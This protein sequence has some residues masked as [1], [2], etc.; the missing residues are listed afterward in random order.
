MAASSL[1]Y[2]SRYWAISPIV[3]NLH[4][5]RSRG[6][7]ADGLIA[8]TRANPLIKVPVSLCHVLDWSPLIFQSCL[9]GQCTT[10][11]SFCRNGQNVPT[12][13]KYSYSLPFLKIG[14]LTPNLY[15]LKFCHHIQRRKRY[16]STEGSRISSLSLV[17]SLIEEPISLQ[18]LNRLLTANRVPR[19]HNRWLEL[20]NVNQAICMDEGTSS[21]PTNINLP[22]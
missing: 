16:S 14:H 4:I 21:L 13:L 2:W 9:T 10:R 15:I 6:P 7:Q 12:T 8:P 22:K 20:V 17:L 18:L 11:E 19:R 5:W 1:Y 3:S